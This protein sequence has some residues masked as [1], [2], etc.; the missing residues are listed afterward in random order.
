MKRALRQQETAQKTKRGA[1]FA[2]LSCIIR[3]TGRPNQRSRPAAVGLRRGGGKMRWS[4][5]GRTILPNAT[6]ASG[7]GGSRGLKRCEGKNKRAR[8]RCLLRCY[9]PGHRQFVSRTT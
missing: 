8:L 1:T 2:P 4:E 5:V 3:C 7:N 9:F 6:S